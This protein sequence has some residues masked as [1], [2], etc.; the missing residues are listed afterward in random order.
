M[1][2]WAYSAAVV[3]LAFLTTLLLVRISYAQRSF[4]TALS[5]K[6]VQGFYK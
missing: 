1:V 3:L 5:G 2:A 6:D 4:S